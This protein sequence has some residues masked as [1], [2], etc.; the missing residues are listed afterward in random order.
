MQEK[1]TV[2]NYLEMAADS[3]KVR[4]TVRITSKTKRQNL[5]EEGVALKL[6]RGSLFL[7]SWEDVALDQNF[8]KKV[9]MEL[10]KDI[11]ELFKVHP[12]FNQAQ[13]LWIM[14]CYANSSLFGGVEGNS[15]T[16]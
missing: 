16:K 12:E 10:E 14:S 9:C 6:V 8:I 7:A 3:G 2:D 11:D 4:T 1:L 15:E 13:R 5:L